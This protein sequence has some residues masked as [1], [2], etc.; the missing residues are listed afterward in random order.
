MSGENKGEDGWLQGSVFGA[1]RSQGE[2]PSGR[3]APKI[4]GECEGMAVLIHPL[5][6]SS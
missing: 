1:I 4:L 6:F 2:Q 5:S 3:E